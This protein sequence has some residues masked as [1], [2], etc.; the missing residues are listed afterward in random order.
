[1]EN[2]RQTIIEKINKNK[3]N[4]MF[5]DILNALI[6]SDTYDVIEACYFFKHE[7]IFYGNKNRIMNQVNKLVNEK[8]SKISDIIEKKKLLKFLNEIHIEDDIDDYS[9]ISFMISQ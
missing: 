2:E 8:S 5:K 9:Y 1:M 6:N 7:I 4:I 3:C